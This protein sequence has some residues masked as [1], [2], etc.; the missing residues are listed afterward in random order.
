MRLV[1]AVIDTNV[2][3]SGI[4]NAG[5]EAGRIATALRAADFELV[6]S[7]SILDEVANVLRREHVRQELV[8]LDENEIATVVQDLRELADVVPGSY[9]DVDMVPADPNDNHVVA[10]ALEGLAD[11]LVT[12]DQGLLELHFK[13]VAAHRRVSMMSP[14]AFLQVLARMK[15][16]R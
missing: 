8:D 7:K 9:I 2:L 11:Y 13:R 6:I 5:G 1:R 16:A 15:A 4:A 10:C 14:R 12:R 3:V